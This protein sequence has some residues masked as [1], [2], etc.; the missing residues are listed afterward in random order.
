MFNGAAYG[1][2]TRDGRWMLYKEEVCRVMAAR[3]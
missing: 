1:R 3:W 2:A